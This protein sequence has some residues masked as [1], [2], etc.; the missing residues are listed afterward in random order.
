MRGHEHLIALRKRGIKPPIVFLN[1]FP[2]ATDWFAHSEHATVSTGCGP[3]AGLDLRCVVGMVVSIASFDQ[4][5]AQ[6]L[7]EACKRA[8]ACAVAAAHAIRTNPCRVD[9]GWAEIWHREAQHG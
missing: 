3:L 6:R 2:C 5:R 4:G 9:T 1:D 8:G 7:A